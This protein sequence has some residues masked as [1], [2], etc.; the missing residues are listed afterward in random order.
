MAQAK[1]QVKELWEAVMVEEKEVY[2]VMEKPKGRVMAPRW[3]SSTDL[4]SEC[5]WARHHYSSQ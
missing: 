5:S 3:A 2:K 1:G 4:E